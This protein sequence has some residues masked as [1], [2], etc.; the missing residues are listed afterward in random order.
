MTFSFKK[1]FWWLTFLAVILLEV[2]SF[3]GYLYPII[4]SLVYIVLLL[5]T[6]YLTLKNISWGLLVAFLELVIG[7]QGYLFSLDLFGWPLSLRIGIWLI[8][9]SIWLFRFLQNPRGFIDRISWFK[10]LKFSYLLLLL[11]I[12]WGIASGFLNNQEF[13]NIFFDANGWFYWTLILPWLMFEKKYLNYLWNIFTAGVGWVFIKTV[14]ILYIFSHNFG[15]LIELLYLWLRDFRIGE[16]T[17]VT[18][19]FWRVFMQNQSMAL[20]A[21]FIVIVWLWFNS[22]SVKQ[23]L[24][25]YKGMWLFGLA[26][27]TTLLLS[28]SRSFWL[29]AAVTG[30]VFLIYI[31]FV[32]KFKWQRIIVGLLAV[33]TSVIVS[34]LFILV[35]INFPLPYIEP[36]ASNLIAGRIAGVTDEAAGGSRLALLGPLTDKIK[37]NFILGDGFGSTVTYFSRDPR[38]VA[39]TAGQSGKYTTY[40]FEWGYHD[41]LLKIGLLGLLIYF[42]LF[43]K[44]Y[45]IGL[46]RD[47]LVV[48]VLFALLTL[49]F[50]NITT[51]YLNHPLGIGVIIVVS[52]LILNYETT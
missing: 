34:I 30:L 38:V 3:Y 33:L 51:P 16:I 47:I 6:L 11:A 45:K 42:Y 36:V 22:S 1:E 18:G 4:N 10:P 41:I 28:Y 21:L 32:K 52:Y 7:S 14:I 43:Y 5:I 25:Q 9:M 40:A 39:A 19:N 26:S 15:G 12:L 27:L 37:G 49:L 50:V 2:L 17:Y 48:G 13:N 20:V 24:K 8:I 23:S 35:V 46:K 31:I 29:G 44:L